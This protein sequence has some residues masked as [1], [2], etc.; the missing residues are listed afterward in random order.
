MGTTA[1]DAR[2]REDALSAPREVCSFLVWNVKTAQQ[3]AQN[4]N[5]NQSVQ[6]VQLLTPT[7]KMEFAKLAVKTAPS[8]P[9]PINAKCVLPMECILQEEPAENALLAA[10]LALMTQHVYPALVHQLT[11]QVANV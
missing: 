4:V 8:A 3:D 5:Q 2:R 6:L 10:H 7:L 11:S 9:E 1:R